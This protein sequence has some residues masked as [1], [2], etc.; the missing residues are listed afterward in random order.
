[1]ATSPIDFEANNLA[2]FDATDTDG[3]ELST[4]PAA[5]M[6]GVYGMQAH[7]KLGDTDDKY[8]Q[9][10]YANKT[11]IRVGFYFD[12]NTLT[13]AATD[14]IY[15]A[16]GGATIGASD[17]RILLHFDAIAGYQIAVYVTTNAGASTSPY[18]AL[19]DEKHWLE[20]YFRRSTAPGALNGYAGLWID[21]VDATVDTELT[22]IDDDT[23]DHDNINVG[24]GSVDATVDGFLYFDYICWNDSGNDIGAPPEAGHYAWIF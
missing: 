4:S 11:R 18:V 10:T 2:E 19:T 9:I 15:I 14:T 13:M 21:T 20:A 24:A 12:P 17:W 5:A 6:W 3:G 1:M 16:G 22:N 23:L 7:I 8:G